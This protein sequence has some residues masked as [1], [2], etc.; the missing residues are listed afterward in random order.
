VGK[1][2]IVNRL[3]GTALQEVRATR[4]DDRG[5]H[6]TTRRELVVLPEHGV[7]IDTP[8]LRELALWDA[9]SGLDASFRDVLVLAGGCRFSD[10]GHNGEPGCAVAAAVADGSLDG[11]RLAGFRKLQRELAYLERRQ[12]QQA[13]LAQ[14]QRWKQITKANRQRSKGR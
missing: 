7:I 11:G 5:R 2:S 4:Q 9:G 13:A 6:T 10:C 1:S 3:C 8:G 12:D 14:R